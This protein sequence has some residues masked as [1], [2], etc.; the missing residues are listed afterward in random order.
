MKH[1]TENQQ[2]LQ[3]YKDRFIMK[4]LPSFSRD[5]KLSFQLNQCRSPSLQEMSDQEKAIY[6]LQTR[7]VEQHEYLFFYDTDCC[8]TVSRYA[9]IKSIG[10]RASNE[11]SGP[12]TLGG[13]DN[14]QITSSR[15]TYQV[16]L[17]LFIGNDTVLSGV[18]LD[19]ITVEFS[20]YPLKGLVEDNVRSAYI[21]NRKD[22][23]YLPK[24]PAFV[25]DPTDFIIGVKYL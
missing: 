4:Q 11:F 18:R 6:I 13:V 14:A 21:L 24:L 7:K 15:G 16:K 20:K 2:L 25:G 23:K 19:Q 9:A 1:D 12:V 8:D 10:K 17:F 22:R 3:K 5:L